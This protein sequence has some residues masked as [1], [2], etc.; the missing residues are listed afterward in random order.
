MYIIFQ[1]F[2]ISFFY[3]ILYMSIISGLIGIV[4]LLIR[5]FTDKIISPKCRCF[6]WI[7]FIIT[8]IFP[9]SIPSKYSI[10]NYVNLEDKIHKSAIYKYEVDNFVN[11]YNKHNNTDISEFMNKSIK[12]E[13][14]I[15]AEDIIIDILVIISS[16][17]IFKFIISYIIFMK[18]IGNDEI[19]I[20]RIDKIVKRC[21]K[22]LK[23]KR[24]IKILRQ[25]IV[26][27]PAIIGIFNI[28]ILFTDSILT[29][30][31][32]AICDIIIHELSHYKRK[33]NISNFV[34][35]FL[36][37]IYWFNPIVILMLKYIRKDFELATDFMAID[38]MELN[39]RR[40]Y[41][42]VM[43]A[44][45]T[46]NNKSQGYVLGM[47]NN[48]KELENRIDTISLKQR[49]E[50]YSIVISIF[51]MIIISF[52]GLVFYPTSY[53]MDVTDKLYLKLDNFEEILIS[54]SRGNNDILYAK[55]GSCLKF[56]NYNKYKGKYVICTQ[57]NLRNGKSN[58][59]FAEDKIV[60]YE[61]GEFSFTFNIRYSDDCTEEYVVKIIVE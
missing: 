26:K 38:N 23:I 53:G 58:T 36:K 14:K 20:E 6:I 42:K 29:L 50:K 37:S 44:V 48:I 55:C 9:I 35:N 13:N 2:I 8:L 32:D 27:T 21:K 25:N 12:R 34:I 30:E 61:K 39:E 7:I 5:K 40:K 18:Q 1:N 3:K 47:A 10:Y 60:F 16:F 28:R 43:L 46:M 54:N 49:F 52:I 22:R 41:C 17:N 11:E 51:T 33:D 59:Y 15:G 31:D 45:S 4:I 19:R 57:T 56:E 24:N